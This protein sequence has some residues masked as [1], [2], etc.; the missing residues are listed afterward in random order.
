MLASANNLLQQ[1]AMGLCKLHPHLAITH[2]AHLVLLER[3]C[4]P[5]QV[6]PCGGGGGCSCCTG[7]CIRRSADLHVLHCGQAG[8]EEEGLVG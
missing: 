7:R 2:P 1:P 4:G 8:W 5:R 3:V 6:P